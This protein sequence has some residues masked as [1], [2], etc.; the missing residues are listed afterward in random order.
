VQD[1]SPGVALDIGCGVGVETG[2]LIGKGW[3]VDAIDPLPIQKYVLQ[4]ID[5]SQQAG[6]N[7]IQADITDE[8]VIAQ[9][10]SKYDLIIALG[11]LPF[12][13]DLSA[14]RKI[15]VEMES[16]LS[17]DGIFIMS[18]LGDKHEWNGIYKAFFLSIQ[19]ITEL[20]KPFKIIHHET[21][22]QPHDGGNGLA[23]VE[24]HTVVAIK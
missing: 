23:H 13:N 16:R 14:I 8:L 12:L 24:Y 19:E 3:K 6:L 7:L 4:R 11:S 1:R 21:F 2:Y 18:F 20:I 17:E 15:I 10:Q 9:L 5:P 22:N